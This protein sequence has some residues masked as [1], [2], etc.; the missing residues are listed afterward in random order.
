MLQSTILKIELLYIALKLVAALFRFILEFLLIRNKPQINFHVSFLK[1]YSIAIIVD[2][3]GCTGAI[4]CD[5]SKI[6]SQ[7]L[8][9]VLAKLDRINPD[10][11]VLVDN[12]LLFFHFWLFLFS[13][14]FWSIGFRPDV[15][16][17]LQKFFLQLLFAIFWLI[18]INFD[19]ITPCWLKWIENSEY[20]LCFDVLPVIIDQSKSFSYCLNF[21]NFFLLTLPQIDV[22]FLLFFKLF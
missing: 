14:R 1:F 15:G 22:Y 5:H 16:R 18:N 13:L 10:L 6:V 7:S 8:F 3:V 17:S 20:I 11:L 2:I 21:R 12:P 4:K 19:Y 9:L